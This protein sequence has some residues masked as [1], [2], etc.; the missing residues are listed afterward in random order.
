MSKR[1]LF[2][3]KKIGLIIFF[4]I[5]KIISP[6]LKFNKKSQIKNLYYF[7][8]KNWTLEEVNQFLKKKMSGS[9]LKSIKLLEMN[10]LC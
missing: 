3:I 4:Q 8:V 9:F 2:I 6:Y 1:T 7:Q 5:F 10:F